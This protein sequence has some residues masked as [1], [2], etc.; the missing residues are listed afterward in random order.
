VCGESNTYA[1]GNSDTQRQ[2][3]SDVNH[4]TQAKHDA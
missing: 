4:N 3:N 2:R 1:A